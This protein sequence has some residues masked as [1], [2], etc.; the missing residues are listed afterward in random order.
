[1]AKVHDY[2]EMWQGSQNVHAAQKES[3][4]Q[5]RQMTAIRYISDTEDFVKAFWSKYPH[6]C[7]ATFKFWVQSPVP[8]AFSAKYLPGGRTQLLNARGIK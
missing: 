5:N 4:A 6:A 1:M 8:P 2:L 7:A 3:R